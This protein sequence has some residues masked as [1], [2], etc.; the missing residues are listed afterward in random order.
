M[1]ITYLAL[2]TNLGDRFAH[3]Q[4]ALAAFPPEIRVRGR[5]RIYET[6]AWGYEEQPA[7]LNMVIKAETELSPAALLAHLKALESDL[8]RTPTFRW[9]PRVIDIDI[10]FYD[11][12]TLDSPD[13]TIPHPRLHERAFVLVPLSDLAPDLVHPRLGNTVRQLLAQ[14]DASG[15]ESYAEEA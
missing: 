5:S 6:P 4:A 3:L 15:I 7:F 11:A 1:A 10:L 8:G 9:G 14:V 2:G 12:I 13:L